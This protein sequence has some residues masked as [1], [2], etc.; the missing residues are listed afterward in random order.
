MAGGGGSRL[1][2]LSRTGHPKQFLALGHDRLSLFQQAVSRLAAVAC[3]DIAVQPA[4]VVG[5]EEHRFLLADQLQEA[6]VVPG[7]IVLEPAGRNT[8]PALALAALH[9]V[10]QGED[11]VLVVAPA[12][13]VFASEA[14]G[15]DALRAAVRLAA[16]GSI[17]LLGVPPT[18]PETGYGYLRAEPHEGGLRV[19][20]FVEKPDLATAEDYLA[21]GGYLWNAGIFVLRASVWL[22]ALARFHPPMAQLASQAWQARSHDGRFVRPDATVFAQIPAVS[23]DYAVM[24]K[25]PGSPFDIRVVPLEAGWSDLGAWDAVWQFGPRDGDGNV[26]IGDA[27]ASES[28]DCLVHAGSRL[29]SVVGL[30]GVVVV[31]TAD[32]VLVMDKARAQD[33]RQVAAALEAEGRPEPALARKVHRPWGWYDS[34]DAGP[35]FQVK[36]IMVKPGAS[37]SL[38]LH[39]HRAEHWVVVAGTAEV[40]RGDETITLEANQ[41]TYIPA[42]QKHRLANRGT[43]PLELIEV[44]SGSY[45]GE[46][47][48]VRFD[49]RYGRA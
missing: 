31:E 3:A 20:Q 37:L 29:V 13:H 15:V 46:D 27:R 32:A 35:H 14:A 1:W 38:Q 24:E 2:P 30:E 4:L 36:R 6:G 7:A 34:V 43:A 9:A 47:D 40:T 10:Q 25:C 48:I 5:N 23:I 19:A 11:P 39:H 17:V 22:A 44:Q 12:D 45:L 8:A 49:D 18:R 21:R 26:L 41:S 16:G 42:G 33:V 28:R